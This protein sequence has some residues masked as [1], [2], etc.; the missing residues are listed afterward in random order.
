LYGVY[1]VLVI[2]LSGIPGLAAFTLT[3]RMS[4][5]YTFGR[6]KRSVAFFFQMRANSPKK[7]KNTNMMPIWLCVKTV[8][9]GKGSSSSDMLTSGHG[10]GQPGGGRR[11]PLARRTRQ[12]QGAAALQRRKIEVSG[13]GRSICTAQ[14]V[15]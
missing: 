2:V 6:A 10:A 12:R 1:F 8:D 9:S 4:P 5:L 14:R 13:R 15:R 3:T 11:Q 7:Q